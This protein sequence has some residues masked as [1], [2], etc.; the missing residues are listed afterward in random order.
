M[1]PCNGDSNRRNV[2]LQKAWRFMKTFFGTITQQNTRATWEADWA[3]RKRRSDRD[4][5]ATAADGVN[6]LLSSLGLSTQT[7]TA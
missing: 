6:V 4:L 2:L 1:E 5:I 7:A 3:Q